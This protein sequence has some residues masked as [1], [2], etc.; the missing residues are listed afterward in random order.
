[1]RYNINLH[2]P[3]VAADIVVTDSLLFSSNLEFANRPCFQ[4]ELFH[5]SSFVVTFVT[6]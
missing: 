3:S 1:M 2:L 6:Y 5:S 4:L